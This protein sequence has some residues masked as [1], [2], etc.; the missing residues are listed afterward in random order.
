MRTSDFLKNAHNAKDVNMQK[1]KRPKQSEQMFSLA[2]LGT[3]WI[4]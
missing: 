2:L 1:I 3:L 4:L